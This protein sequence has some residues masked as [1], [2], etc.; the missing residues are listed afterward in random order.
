MKE[1]MWSLDKEGRIFELLKSV[2]DNRNF[3]NVWQRT[4]ENTTQARGVIKSLDRSKCVIAFSK[5][6]GKDFFSNREP[7]FV[8][9]E[10]IDIIFK[11]DN[12]SAEADCIVFKTPT[13]LL[14]KEKRRIERMTFRYQDYKEVEFSFSKDGQEYKIK[15]MLV[16]ISILGIGFVAPKS[17]TENLNKGD[18][19]TI[20]MMTDQKLDTSIVKARVVNCI[21]NDGTENFSSDYVKYGV[22]FEE[23]LELVVFQSKDLVV[24]K[25]QRKKSTLN[26]ES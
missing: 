16:D 17:L 19:I 18:E 6:I 20:H 23:P 5:K 26:E 10:G 9:C 4:K 12:F 13:K 2:V 22:E 15:E 25:T 3:V 24:P 14:V 11:K 8:H 7:L 1:E 21:E